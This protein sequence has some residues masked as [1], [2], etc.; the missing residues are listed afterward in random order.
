M[1]DPRINL[2]RNVIVALSMIA[3]AA[4]FA[5]AYHWTGSAGILATLFVAAFGAAAG[6]LAGFALADPGG[7]IDRLKPPPRWVV[8][9]FVLMGLGALCLVI[10]IAAGAIFS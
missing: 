5:F 8:A 6:R 7:L 4:L 10:V 9:Q 3:G 2:N 1:S